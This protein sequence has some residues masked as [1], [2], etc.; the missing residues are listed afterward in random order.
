MWILQVRKVCWKSGT[1]VKEDGQAYV[2]GNL[3]EAMRSHLFSTP[4]EV[5]EIIRMMRNGDRPQ[6]AECI[7]L[8]LYHQIKAND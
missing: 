7:D 6:A 1:L 2:H 5:R 8:V 3:L 4:D